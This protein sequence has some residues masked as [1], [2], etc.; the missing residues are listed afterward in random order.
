MAIVEAHGL[1]VWEALA[2]RA[3]GRPVGPVDAGLWHAVAERLNPARA[4]PR[5]RSEIEY[6]QLTSARGVP[7]V[8]LRSPDGAAACY[9]RLTPEEFV[10]AGLMDGSRTVARL[11][12]E[13]ARV[14]GRLAP[15]QVTRVV[16]DLAGN[17]M[18]EELPVDAFVRLQRVHRRSWP[19]RLGRFVVAAARGQ[20]VVLASV[21]PLVGLLYRVGGRWLFT[22]VAAVLCGLVAVAGLGVFVWSWWLG[23]SSVFLT[24]DSYVTGALVLLGLNVVALGCHELGHA[25]AAKHAGRRVPV[26]GFLV[27]FGIPSVFVD[28]TDVWMAGRR[29]RV[30]TT[31]AG[32]ATGLVLAGVSQLVGLVVPE[33]APW[34]FKLAFAWY[35]NALF[36]LNPF[37]A[38]DGY[39]LLMDWLEVPN[40]RARGMAWVLARLR[41]RPPRFGDLDSEGRLVA[42]YGLLAVAWLAIA[43]NLAY[44]VYVDRV[45]GLVTGL[46]HAGWLAR[47]L[48]AVVVVGL[49]APLVWVAVG[50]L[51]RRLH[52]LR[53][54]LGERRASRDAPRRLAVLRGSALGRLPVPML[55]RLAEQ[56]RWLHPRTG[57][58]LVF[59]GAAASSVFVVAEGGGGGAPAG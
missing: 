5:L 20:R 22:R 3:P 26:A 24:G 50:W 7:Y 25:L 45:G 46:W 57:E 55:A 56:A 58:Q 53:V 33:L 42:L 43:A 36:N 32:P 27:Y 37:L 9:L 14:A 35:L 49:A 12:A 47:V 11:V 1:S 59:A 28:T 31:A 19:V 17:R 6:A 30:L 41:R 2:G 21:D 8:M 52:R 40:L 18:L 29:A 16:A 15:E 51:G 23:A 34:T 39:Y 4:R 54:R 10:L 13:F 48:L 44:R 38:L